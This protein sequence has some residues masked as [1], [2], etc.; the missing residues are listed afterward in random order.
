MTSQGDVELSVISKNFFFTFFTFFVAFTLIGTAA[1]AFGLQEL[2]DNLKDRLGDVLGTGQVLA[3]ALGSLGPFYMNLVVLQAFGIFPLRLLEFGSVFLYPIGLMGAK[4]PR[5]KSI[6]LREYKVIL[7]NTVDYADLVQP[8]VF[9]YGFFLPQTIFTFVICIIYSILPQSELLVLFGLVYFLM[10]SFIYKYQLL[11]AM[12]HRN[13]STGRAWPMICNRIVVGLAFFQ[14]AM[15]GQLLLSGAWRRSLL[16][17]PLFIGT[18]WFGVFYQRTFGPL[19]QFIALRSLH[20][21]HGEAQS[22]S[23]SR[24]EERSSQSRNRS[25]EEH[26]TKFVNPSLVVGLED[27]WV[28]GSHASNANGTG[29]E[30]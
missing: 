4:T 3:Q 29:E 5:G 6:P 18:V 9:S 24:Y 23:E 30:D 13:F 16:V 21:T 17:V 20:E 14:I 26:H 22:L 1:T 25:E 15:G 12:D 2:S 28:S 10:G 19:T 7:S 11:Y 27:V 8:P